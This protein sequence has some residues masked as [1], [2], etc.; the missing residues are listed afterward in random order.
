M[1]VKTLIAGASLLLLGATVAKS[2]D[3]PLKRGVASSFTAQA[4][5]A[6]LNQLDFSNRED[7]EF[8]TR[9]FIATLPDPHIK[10]KDGAVLYDLNAYAFLRDKSAPA[11]ANPSLWRQSQ[12]TSLSGLYKVTDK[13]YQIRGFDLSNMTL[14]Q[15][16]TGWIIIDPL[17][18]AE[19]AAAG[20]QLA[21]EKLGKRPI[22]AV[23][24]THSH[25]DHFGGVLGIVTDAEIKSKK[26]QII[27]P[28]GFLAEAIS[29]NLY[30]GN[31]MARRA[32]YM[33]GS[34]IQNGPTGNLGTGLGPAVSNGTHTIA[35]PNK[36][37]TKTGEKMTVDG[38]EMVFQNAPG[39]EAPAEMLFYF[40]QLK[41]LCLSEDATATMH[42]LYTLRGAKV[43]SPLVWA[44]AL[45]ET[46]ELFGDSAQVSFASHHWPRWGNAKIKEFITNQRDMYKFI[47][48]Q[49]LKM[50]NQ[51]Y[52]AEEIAEKLRLP[53]SLG[54]KFYN[55][56]YYGSLSHNVRATYQLYLGFYNGNPANLHKHP[57]IEAG[58]RYVA[59]I[60]GANQVL[61][62]GRNAFNKGD[63]RWT[64]ELVNHLVYADPNNKEARELQAAAL[65]QMGFQ[66]ESGPWRDVYLAGASE[67]RDGVPQKAIP[68]VD[69]R[70]LPLAMLFDYTAIRL[71]ADKAAGKR[72]VIAINTT[73]TK[74]KYIL[75]LNNSVL[76]ANKAQASDKADTTLTMTSKEAGE[77]FGGFKS[78]DELRQSGG[79]KMSGKSGAVTDLL[80]MLDT[81]NPNFNLVTPVQPAKATGRTI[82][83]Q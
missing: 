9:G 44:N 33:Y 48:D 12:L 39:T 24:F 11:T 42:N 73:D 71:N 76:F 13:I 25:I 16:N 43:R 4:N 14:I 83:A 8:A 37:I 50:A 45:N 57:R 78:M 34:Y 23:I 70:T 79:L 68:L 18:S 77:L 32:I 63:Y 65:E 61:K 49:T 15:G 21:N 60:G 47:N 5:Q 31:A 54:K 80:A 7:F 58:K 75:T 81:F 1:K 74:E 20:L 27:A 28:V 66:A 69:T 72:S 56:G 62:L 41:A 17:T 36:T 51:G 29:E 64:A 53:D 19:T 26:V 35:V 38:I 40:P 82:G 6:V 30:A 3:E 52:D 2:A 55:R 59:A 67:L 22:K 10:G 46:L